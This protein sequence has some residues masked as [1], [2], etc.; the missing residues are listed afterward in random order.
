[1]SDQSIAGASQEGDYWIVQG[2]AVGRSTL[3]V[4]H[5]RKIIMNITHF[6]LF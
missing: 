3:A 4:S 6:L 5:P 1:M 2:K